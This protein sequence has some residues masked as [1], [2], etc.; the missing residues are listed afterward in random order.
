MCTRASYVFT[1]LGVNFF[2]GKRPQDTTLLLP[3]VG[4][5]RGEFHTVLMVN[6]RSGKSAEGFPDLRHV[7]RV[8]MSHVGPAAGF[9][10]AQELFRKGFLKQTVFGVTPLGPRIGEENEDIVELAVGA[11]KEENFGVHA[12]DL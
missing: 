4:V 5:E 10:N 1:I 11:L 12:D 3:L 8:V 6:E 7:A 9:K 2:V